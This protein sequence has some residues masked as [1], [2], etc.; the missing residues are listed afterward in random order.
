MIFIKLSAVTTHRTSRASTE[1]SPFDPAPSTATKQ[2]GLKFRSPPTEERRASQA[3]PNPIH[4]ALKVTHPPPWFPP[5]IP[6]SELTLMNQEIRTL[7]QERIPKLPLAARLRFFQANWSK[8]SHD[9]VILDIIKGLKLDFIKNPSS[10]KERR[11]RFLSPRGEK[12]MEEEVSNMLM[13]GAIREVTETQGQFLSHLFL[14]EKKDG[15]QRPIIDL[16]ELNTHIP[17]QHFKMETLNTLKD[18][19]LLNDYMV[20]IDLK[21]AYFTVPLHESMRKYVRFMWKG[22]TF[23]FLC[24][25]FGLSPGP[26]TFTKIMKVPTSLR[27][28]LNIRLII[29]LD[30]M[31][32]LGKSYQETLSHLHTIIY[33]MQHLGFIINQKKSIFTPSQEIEFLGLII[34]SRDLTLRLP[35]EKITNI[36][37]RCTQAD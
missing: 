19:L 28:R 11:P 16:K 17:Y 3:S 10:Q 31:L 7:I 6:D 26:R 5:L 21:D 18:I 22:T 15:S 29:F 36:Q 1:S 9:P 37:Q 30:D 24:L 20:K 2:A 4:F 14:K 35:L 12:L 13:K 25:C 23:E 27:R 34:N 33:L 32:V 8:I